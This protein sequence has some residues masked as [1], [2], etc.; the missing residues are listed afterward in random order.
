MRG[1]CWERGVRAGLAGYVVRTTAVRGKWF[2]LVV[3]SVAISLLVSS[4]GFSDNGRGFSP[5][6]EW[7]RLCR[8]KAAKDCPGDLMC[9]PPRTPNGRSP[10]KPYK[11]GGQGLS[12]AGKTVRLR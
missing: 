3:G 6:R 2:W 12:I 7:G 8:R 9:R 4:C 11:L 5:S 10:S 1:T